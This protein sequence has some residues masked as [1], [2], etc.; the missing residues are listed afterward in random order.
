MKTINNGKKKGKV[1][2][3]VVKIQLTNNRALRRIKFKRQKKKRQ[4]FKFIN[5]Y[6]SQRIRRGNKN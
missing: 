1:E 2:K 5:K 4:I 3:S 6:K